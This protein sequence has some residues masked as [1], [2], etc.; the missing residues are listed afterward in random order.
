MSQYQRLYRQNEIRQVREDTH[1]K[2]RSNHRGCHRHCCEVGRPSKRRI[3]DQLH[4][5][6]FNNGSEKLCAFCQRQEV[7]THRHHVCANC[8][9]NSDI[10]LQTLLNGGMKILDENSKSLKPHK[11]KFLHR[12]QKR[13]LVREHRKDESECESESEGE[14]E[15]ENE[16]ES[17]SENES[18]NE[19][20]S[21]SY[22]D[23]EY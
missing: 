23:S 11:C 5:K 14:S 4:L 8:R 12:H 7:D 19:S 16:S 2:K 15:S 3:I 20:E 13:I 18:E 6:A 10:I 17:K 22:N 9:H 1:R 21:E